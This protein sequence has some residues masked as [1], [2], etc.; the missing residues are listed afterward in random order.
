MAVSVSTCCSKK[1]PPGDKIAVYTAIFLLREPGHETRRCSI[2]RANANMRLLEPRMKLSVLGIAC[3]LVVAQPAPALAQPAPALAQPYPSKPIRMLVGLPAGS[4]LDS[5]ARAVTS[6]L[7]ERLHQNVVVDNR[8]GAGGN[9]AAETVAR[10]R[11]DGYTLL[12][13]AFGALAVNPN[14]YANLPYDSSR[15]FAPIARVVDA[16]NVLVINPSVPASTVKELVALAKAKPLLAGSAGIGTPGHL[17]LALFNLIAGT[18]VEHVVYKGSG[19]A[20]LD[21]MAGAVH[22]VFATS[23]TGVPL[24]KAGKLKGLAVSTAK[25]SALVPELPTMAEA[26]LKDF[27]VSG[28]Y[29]AFAPAGTPQPIVQRLNA[30]IV[31]LLEL[32]DVRQFLFNQGLE[33]NPSTPDEMGAQLRSDIARW[34]KVIKASGIK[35]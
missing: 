3:A 9:I 24:M 30:E 27:E 20:L 12:M 13:G 29:G 35:P 16:T 21:L 8:S 22:M 7:S 6:R 32:P 26:G 14:L 2:D 10:A 18:Q 23:S 28:W 17:S 11:P 1:N 5:C 25:R 19:P 15:D 4:S 33:V 31:K 34:G